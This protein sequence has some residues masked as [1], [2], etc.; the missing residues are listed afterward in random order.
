VAVTDTPS[1]EAGRNLAR[2]SRWI[3]PKISLSYLYGFLTCHE[4]LRQGADGFSSLRRKSCYAVKIPL[5][6][7]GFEP[8]NCG[9]SG[10]HDNHYATEND[11]KSCWYSLIW[12]LIFMI[13]NMTSVGFPQLC[14]FIFTFNW[15]EQYKAIGYHS[16]VDSFACFPPRFYFIETNDKFIQSLDKSVKHT[17]TTK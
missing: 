3:L 14:S 4:I 16:A 5:P 2:N 15:F 6:S 10:K 13:P 12:Y 1:S 17:P 8:A 7:A 9:H 11:L